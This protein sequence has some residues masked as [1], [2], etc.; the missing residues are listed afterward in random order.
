MS[1]MRSSRFAPS[2]APAAAA[3]FSRTTVQ[4]ISSPAYDPTSTGGGTASLVSS[5]SA[6]F[7]SAMACAGTRVGSSSRNSLVSSSSAAWMFASMVEGFSHRSSPFLHPRC[8]A[9]FSPVSSSRSSR[10][11]SVTI[12]FSPTPEPTPGTTRELRRRAVRCPAR[13]SSFASDDDVRPSVAACAAFARVAGLGA[14]SLVATPRRRA[15]SVSAS[16]ATSTSAIAPTAAPA[17]TH[18]PVRPRSWRRDAAAPSS[19]S[20]NGT[21]VH[22]SSSRDARIVASDSRGADAARKTHRF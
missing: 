20:S 4:S 18:R 3:F 9:L 5:N 14:A 7:T 15:G 1:R 16:A 17:A 12:S 2:A 11:A 13:P 22:R 19:G 21:A 10:S 6:H 8:A